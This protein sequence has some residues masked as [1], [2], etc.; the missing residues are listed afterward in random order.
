MP[1]PAGSVERRSATL[2]LL[3]EGRKCRLRLEGEAY[4][5]ISR[6]GRSRHVRRYG[7]PF[8][9]DQFQ[10][11]GSD[12]RQLVVAQEIQIERPFPGGRQVIV[13][14]TWILPK[15]FRVAA[16]EHHD[17]RTIISEGDP[18]PGFEEP[19][20]I[21]ETAAVMFHTRNIGGLDNA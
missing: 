17:H 2:H 4:E 5:I 3:E 11:L 8:L 16:G 20:E 18:A 15:A 19:W 10:D 13:A 21:L 6:A 9:A 1:E 7:G 14:G 12:G